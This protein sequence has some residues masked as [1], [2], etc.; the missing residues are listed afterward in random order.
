MP[1]TAPRG[2]ITSGEMRGPEE[3]RDF[4]RSTGEQ[5]DTPTRTNGPAA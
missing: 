3:S 4:T 5:G 1:L 2:T